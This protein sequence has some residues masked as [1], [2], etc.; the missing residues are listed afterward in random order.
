MI[1][2]GHEKVKYF[3]GSEVEKTPAFSKK[4]LFVVDY[5]KTDDVL[6][7]ARKHKVTHIFLG[8]NHS[9]DAT[10]YTEYFGQTW[11]KLIVDL[12]DRGYW[13]TLDYP[14]H[15]HETV[16][17]MLTPGV[18][19][20]RIFVPLLSVRIPKLETSNPNLTIKFDDIDFQAT[21]PGVWCLPF[22]EVTDSNRF[23]DWLEYSSDI[24][25]DDGIVE[26]DINNTPVNRVEPVINNPDIG[27]DATGISAMKATESEEEIIQKIST[28]VN[29]DEILR[30]YT[31]DTGK[32]KTAPASKKKV[33]K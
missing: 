30:I 20:S 25:L 9:F 33:K 13:V 17:K 26:E 28:E 1:R 12:L 4:T 27:L 22:H 16:L 15:Q 3:I 23:T 8:A 5:A 21:N 2:S 29:R 31:E 19:Q 7:V 11:N 32:E 24:V 14:A 6:E 18:W 10:H